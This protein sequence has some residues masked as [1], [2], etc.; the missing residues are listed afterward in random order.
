MENCGPRP[1]AD[2]HAQ[3]S[4]YLVDN[5][6]YFLNDCHGFEAVASLFGSRK[7]VPARARDAKTLKEPE[8]AGAEVA[9]AASTDGKIAS[10]D[11]RCKIQGYGTPRCRYKATG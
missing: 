8:G 10:Q 3:A 7:V 4:M 5:L 11:T 1:R 9:A 2:I 6:E